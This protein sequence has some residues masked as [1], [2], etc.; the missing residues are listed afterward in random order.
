MLK[1]STTKLTG[2]NRYEGFA[3]ELIKHLAERL[4]FNYTFVMH[5][6]NEYG[7][8]NTITRTANGMIREIMHGVCFY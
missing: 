7:A 6:D 8:Y 1:Q 4:G 3:V 2:N 5:K